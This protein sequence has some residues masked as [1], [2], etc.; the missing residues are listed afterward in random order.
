M[1]KGENMR[2]AKNAPDA[3]R[4]IWSEG[5]FKTQQSQEAAQAE[6]SIKGYNFPYDTLRMALAR[7]KFLT[8]VDVKGSANYIQKY[9]F[10]EVDD[11]GR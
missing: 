9:P 1:S 3:I 8:K 2:I 11:H 4:I 5:F 7:A 10:D 6:L